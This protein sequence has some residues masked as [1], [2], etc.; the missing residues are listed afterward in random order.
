MRYFYVAFLFFL[1]PFSRVFAIDVTRVYIPDVEYSKTLNGVVHHGAFPMFTI[2]NE[3]LYC[4]EPGIP[5]NSL[6]YQITNDYS[7]SSMIKYE[8]ELI[9]YY[10]YSY[11]SHQSDLYLMA[12]QK[13]IWETLGSTDVYLKST[14]ILKYL[15][16]T[17]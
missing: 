10:G 1:M 11:P 6:S 9:A 15:F 12:T 14:I 3:V 2:D 16:I 17:H 4:I 5:I 8:L 7:L 13:L